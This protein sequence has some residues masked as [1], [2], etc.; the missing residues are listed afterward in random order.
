MVSIVLQIFSLRTLRSVVVR[1][2]CYWSNLASRRCC[3]RLSINH[4]STFFT[5]SS[6]WHGQN[7]KLVGFLVG[8]GNVSCSTQLNICLVGFRQYGDVS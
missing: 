8:T 2:I 6:S 4:P 5:L 3:P 1:E 7:T